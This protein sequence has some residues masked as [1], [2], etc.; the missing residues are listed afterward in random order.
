MNLKLVFIA[1]FLGAM[2]KARCSDHE[3]LLTLF[4]FKIQSQA[5]KSEAASAYTDAE[6]L[7]EPIAPLAFQR[8]KI[9]KLQKKRAKD[10]KDQLARERQEAEQELMGVVRDENMAAY[11]GRTKSR[12]SRSGIPSLASRH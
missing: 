9:K 12:H 1:S 10:G 11:S 4:R 6:E 5:V 8:K 2:F 7:V 3:D